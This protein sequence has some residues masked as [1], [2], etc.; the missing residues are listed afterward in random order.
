TKDP[1]TSYHIEGFYQYKLN[2][3]ITLTPAVIW[4]TAPDHND[5]N[6]NIVIGALRTTFSF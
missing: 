1:N 4:L 3:N 2:D 5:T 6:D